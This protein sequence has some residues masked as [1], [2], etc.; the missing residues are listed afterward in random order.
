[1]KGGK[2]KGHRKDKQPPHLLIDHGQ[3]WSWK[4]GEKVNNE[5]KGRLVGCNSLGRNKVL[6]NLQLIYCIGIRPFIH[7]YYFIDI[8]LPH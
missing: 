4:I 3:Y 8:K 5:K 6:G 1:M 2:G 7:F